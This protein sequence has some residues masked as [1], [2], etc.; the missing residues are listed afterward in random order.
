M[1]ITDTDAERLAELEETGCQIYHEVND[2][3]LE[4]SK[5]NLSFVTVDDYNEMIRDC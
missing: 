5:C 4:C 2:T 3:A 1:S